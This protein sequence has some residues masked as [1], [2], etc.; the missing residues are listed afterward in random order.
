LIGNQKQVKILELS[1]LT[2]IM[3]KDIFH[4]IVKTALQKNGWIITHD[5]YELRVGGVEM[6]IDLGAEQLI[7]AER[8]QTKI[9]VEIKSF[10]APSS[11][12]EFHS[13]HGQFL[14]YRYALEEEEPERSLY[15][16]VP[17][18]TYRTF[19][20]LRFIQTVIRRSQISLVIYDPDQEDIV[21]WQP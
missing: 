15:L 20:S 4:D 5:P 8:D 13:A 6:Y 9:A 18:K 10:I 16:A 12:S 14:D 17:I 1:L 21:Q 11:I 19:F 3:A 2:A 7:A